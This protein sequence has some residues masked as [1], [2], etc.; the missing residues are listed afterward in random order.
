MIPIVIL[1]KISILVFYI[2]RR[3]RYLAAVRANLQPVTIV[4]NAE[5]GTTAYQTN[6][7]P[8][9]YPQNFNNSPPPYSI[10]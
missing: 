6:Y 1:V 7:F 9:G 8:A 5:H 10:R 4:A 3:R 2:R